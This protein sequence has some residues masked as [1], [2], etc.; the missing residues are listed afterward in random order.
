MSVGLSS[1]VECSHFLVIFIGPTGVLTIIVIRSPGGPRSMKRFLTQP[2]P[3]PEGF[4]VA[5]L[6]N[7]RISTT[8]G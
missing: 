8:K 4:V 7:G 5:R 1:R 3:A 6:W 2:L